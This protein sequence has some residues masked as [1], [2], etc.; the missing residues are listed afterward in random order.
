M[1]AVR[2]PAAL[3][4]ARRSSASSHTE[5]CAATES[6]PYTTYGD[7]KCWFQHCGTARRVAVNAASM[8][9]VDGWMAAGAVFGSCRAVSA[10]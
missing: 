9:G 8:W 2:P 1:A 10:A 7:T 6:R 4:A 3:R 5:R